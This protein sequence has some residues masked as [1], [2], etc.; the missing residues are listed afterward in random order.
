[1]SRH[2]SI[3]LRLVDQGSCQ[4]G[5]ELMRSGT[6]SNSRSG[7]GLFVTTSLLSCAVLCVTSI[8]CTAHRKNQTVM[9]HQSSDVCLSDDCSPGE[10]SVGLGASECL[11][12]YFSTAWQPWETCDQ[13]CGAGCSRKTC[14]IST[15]SILPGFE[16]GYSSGQPSGNSQTYPDTWPP[17]SS[18]ILPAQPEMIHSLP[19][20]NGASPSRILMTPVT[21]ESV[22]KEPSSSALPPLISHPLSAPQPPAANRFPRAVRM[23]PELPNLNANP[24]SN[25]GLSPVPSTPLPTAPLP[26]LTPDVSVPLDPPRPSQSLPTVT[27]KLPQP[28]IQS[29]PGYSSP[30]TGLTLPPRRST[31]VTIDVPPGTAGTTLSLP[32]PVRSGS[33]FGGATESSFPDIETPEATQSPANSPLR[34]STPAPSLRR[35]PQTPVPAFIPGP[36]A[37]Y[38]MPGFQSVPQQVAPG[39]AVR[40]FS[41][42]QPATAQPVT[43]QYPAV[44]QQQL[45]PVQQFKPAT[46]WQAVPQSQPQQ[47][48]NWRVIPRAYYQLPGT[49]QM[50]QVQPQ[51]LQPTPSERVIFLPPP[52]RR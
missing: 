20:S 48:R 52:P 28:I 40:Q 16:P 42:I 31:R 36:D 26:Q 9:M 30:G 2:A 27:T 12:G 13:N 11:C 8:G 7:H 3:E 37:T 1:M 6:D 51:R 24:Y 15:P 43:R 5:G 45:Q 34:P 33:N 21:P 4:Q 10:P 39:L 35:Q 19:N 25:P 14:R 49:Q 29:A 47:Q 46:H 41:A 44:S 50:P 17:P 22:S 18:T 32:D 23:N 38:R